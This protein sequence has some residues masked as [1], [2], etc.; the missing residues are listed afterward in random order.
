[1]TT[2]LNAGLARLLLSAGF[3]AAS[4]VPFAKICLGC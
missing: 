3:L 4:L 2:V 1:M